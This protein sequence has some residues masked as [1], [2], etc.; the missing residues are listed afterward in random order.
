MISQNLIDKV[1]EKREFAGLVDSVVAR[2]LEKNGLDVKSAR[3]FLRKYFGIFLTNKIL[4]PT[5]CSDY[6]FFLKKHISSKKRDY[7][8]FYKK[9][10]KFCPQAKCFIDFGAGLNGF[11]YPFILEN[12]EEARYFGIEASKS[13]VDLTNSF[14][15]ERKYSKAEAINEDI[16][17]LSRAEQLLK[18]SEKIGGERVVFILQTI[19]ALE[20]LE[21]DFSKKFLAFLKEKLNE[22]D[23]IV[24]SY[25]M[26]SISGKS[27]IGSKRVWLNKFLEENFKVLL[28]E[29]EFGECFVFFRAYGQSIK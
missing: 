29:E 10:K 27:T 7:S 16:F 17:N 28:K 2:A 21:K 26:R 6:N 13:L 18:E 1:K 22:R 24:L 19:D 5:N 25:S 20:I 15:K 14:F 3:A 9:I 11:S 8:V 12:F 23:L 4:K